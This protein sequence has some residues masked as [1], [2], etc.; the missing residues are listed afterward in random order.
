VLNAWRR[1]GGPNVLLLS[2]KA[3]GVGLTLVEAHRLICV[4]GL[5][6]SNPADREQVIKRIHRYG[7][8]N[9]VQID[10]LC[11]RGSID[12]VMKEAVH[13]SKQRLANHLLRSIPLLEPSCKKKTPNRELCAIGSALMPMWKKEH[14][15]VFNPTS[16]QTNTQDN[17][18]PNMSSSSKKR[19]CDSITAHNSDALLRKKK[20]MKKQ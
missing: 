10:D 7:Q 17:L 19:T 16:R 11:V 15:E 20:R 13:P 6:Q 8:I 12:A 2:M 5:S 4:D 3:G 1:N 14:S 9:P 18:P